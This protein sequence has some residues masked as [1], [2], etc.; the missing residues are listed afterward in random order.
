M[1]YKG[2]HK[3][4]NKSYTQQTWMI[5]IEPKNI[6]CTSRNKNKN[7]SHQANLDKQTHN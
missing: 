1:H 4:L 5:N 2:F 3:M 6:T 7:K